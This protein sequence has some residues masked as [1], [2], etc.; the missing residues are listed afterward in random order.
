MKKLHASFFIL[1]LGA[2]AGAWAQPYTTLGGAPLSLMSEK[3]IA[4]Y[5]DALKTSLDAGKDGQQSSW[6]NPETGA[7]GTIEPRRS[8][9]QGEKACRDV[10][11]ETRAKGRHEKGTWAFCRDAGGA[12]QLSPG[13]T[14]K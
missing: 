2:A 7:S 8:F 5:Q 4:L 10:Y 11:L 12:W 13:A 6:S 1:G 3:D 14:G 9:K